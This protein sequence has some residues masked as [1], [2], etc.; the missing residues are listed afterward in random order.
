MAKT[1]I[2][3]IALCAIL[4]TAALAPLIAPFDSFD[5]TAHD[6]ADAHQPPLTRQSATGHRYWL[7]TDGQGRDIL[8]GL[9]WGLRQSLWIAVLSVGLAMLVGTAVGL[10]AGYRG[11]VARRI[12]MRV[13]EMQLA[14]PSILVAMLLFGVARPFVGVERFE[15]LA[16]WLIVAAIVLADWVLYAR[17]VAATVSAEIAKEYVVAAEAMGYGHLR[18]AIRHILPNVAGPVMSIAMLCL[19]LAVIAEATLSYLGVGLPINQPS[20]GNMIARGQNELYSGKWWG[21]VFPAATLIAVS[22]SIN[23]LAGQLRQRLHE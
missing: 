11:G 14:M 3:R 22:L 23:T 8:S 21:L 17:T 19:P 20:L 6:L 12:A 7:G 16:P 18:I 1:T 4:A 9:A 13:S 10:A 15:A 2:A 5:Q